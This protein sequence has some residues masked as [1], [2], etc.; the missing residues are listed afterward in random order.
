MT[1]PTTDPRQETDAVQDEQLEQAAGGC[2]F[3]GDDELLPT[4]PIF[5]PEPDPIPGLP[6]PYTGS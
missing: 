1:D 5:W 3:V 4:D 2:R 6:L